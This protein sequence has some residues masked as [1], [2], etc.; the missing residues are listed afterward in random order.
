MI[1]KND[2]KNKL[3]AFSAKRDMSVCTEQVGRRVD[4]QKCR[5]R[6]RRCSENRL[7][8][9]GEAKPKG[10][11]RRENKRNE[12]DGK[13]MREKKASGLTQQ[14]VRVL[15]PKNRRLLASLFLSNIV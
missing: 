12:D 2:G 10:G 13:G 4:W 11:K 7:G 8:G 14:S 1:E 5:D 3:Y 9:G 15:P 6:V